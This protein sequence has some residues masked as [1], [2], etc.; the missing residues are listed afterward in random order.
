MVQLDHQMRAEVKAEAEQQNQNQKQKQKPRNSNSNSN[1]ETRGRTMSGTGTG[2]K[3][4]VIFGQAHGGTTWFQSQL[5][6]HSNLDIS[7]EILFHW[8][9]YFCNAQ[10]L[11]LSVVQS[12]MLDYYPLT[13]Q[14]ILLMHFLIPLNSFS[15]CSFLLVC[16]YCCCFSPTVVS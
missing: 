8:N 6:R 11:T 3:R 9:Q 12:L 14:R 10:Q 7:G 5:A 13:S 16:C 4:L 1:S 15:I 2:I